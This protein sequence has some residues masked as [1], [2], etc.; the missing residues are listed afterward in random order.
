MTARDVDDPASNAATVLDQLAHL[1]FTLCLAPDINAYKS[2]TAKLA[3]RPVGLWDF[4]RIVL[5]SPGEELE[6][7]LATVRANPSD[8]QPACSCCRLTRA[9][10]LPG[11]ISL[12]RESL[13]LHHP[14]DF[15]TPN[16]GRQDGDD[17]PI[18]AERFLTLRGVCRILHLSTPSARRLI[19]DGELRAIKIGGSVNSPY[20]ILGADLNDYIGRATVKAP[21]PAANAPDDA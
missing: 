19:K 1:L 4:C 10:E 21:G 8:L 3:G 13:E 11:R 16:N 7:V 14:D 17:V 18:R 5:A 6:A 9:G 2:K 20:R 15:P 12:L